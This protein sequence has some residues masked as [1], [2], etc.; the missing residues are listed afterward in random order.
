MMQQFQ[1]PAKVRTTI[2]A[3]VRGNTVIV[4]QM[5]I[6]VSSLLECAVAL[7][8]RE[9]FLAWNYISFIKKI[10]LQKR[11]YLK[12]LLWKWLKNSHNDCNCL[13]FFKLLFLFI[14]IFTSMRSNMADKLRSRGE[15]HLAVITP[16]GRLLDRW[17]IVLI[18]GLVLRLDVNGNGD[19]LA[20]LHFLLGSDA[21]LD[22]RALSPLF[23]LLSLGLSLLN[24]GQT[25][26][27]ASGLH[28]IKVS[29][30]VKV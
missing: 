13:G 19:R 14:Q 22:R 23:L 18:L 16:T 28:G 30:E 25:C 27:F 2:V 11:Y 20:S 17:L 24:T 26:T 9:G 21:K 12:Y 3:L 7:G 8:T 15:R 5:T 6:E 1:M 10:Y 29:R 4:S